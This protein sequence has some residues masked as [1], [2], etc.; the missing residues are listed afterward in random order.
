MLLEDG[1]YCYEQL[2]LKFLSNVVKDIFM[3]IV[4]V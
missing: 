3:S 1:K 2:Q 4:V